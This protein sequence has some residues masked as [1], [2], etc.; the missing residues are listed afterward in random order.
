MGGYKGMDFQPRPRVTLAR[1]FPAAFESIVTSARTCY[2]RKGIVSSATIDEKAARLVQNLYNAGHHTTFQHSYF[3]FAI[4]NVSRLLVW[5]FLHSQ[6]Y[7]NSEQVSQRYVPVHRD[8]VLIPP[9]STYFR[10]R[11]IRIVETLMD[12]YQELVGRLIEP[13]EKVY[14]ER[15]PARRYQ[16]PRYRN[17]VEKK[18]MEVARYVLPLG[19]TTFLYHTISALTLLR[20]WKTCRS[21]D[22]PAEQ[23]I[24]AQQMV[25]AVIRKEPEYS[26]IL[27]E[28]FSE[29]SLPNPVDST[30][31]PG[32]MADAKA[33][34]DDFDQSLGGRVSCLVAA[35]LSAE[36]RVA[37]A[38][39][40][41][42]GVTSQRLSDEEALALAL[43]PAR[44]PT[45]GES[46]NTSMHM[47]L[48]RAMVVVNYTFKKKISHTADAQDQRHR[49]V[50]AARPALWAAWTGEPDYITPRLIREAPKEIA[51]LYH[52]TMEWLFESIHTLLKRG[53][54]PQYAAY[55]L[56]NAYPVRYFETGDLLNL[57]HKLSM[58]LCYNA[59]EEI[60]QASLDEWEQICQV[61][62]KIGSFLGPP[63]WIRKRAERR[64]F[65][66]EGERF[67]GI[68]VW[69]LPRERYSRI[70]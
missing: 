27:D 21:C 24:V 64:P 41:I 63:C 37:D 38:V 34:R 53:M 60:W 70:L 4:E 10:S 39:R 23:Q 9:L 33:F 26:K 36:Q 12:I 57:R 2:S 52:Q 28:P 5:S 43:D 20:Y 8:H 59:Q 35:D 46:L 40:T 68:R 31:L 22:V 18:A 1:T 29:E 42:L 48:S 45:L 6:P 16:S 51:Q 49:T 3:Q 55:L 61:H 67:C 69:E 54:E 17:A 44:N 58:R 13:A 65:C 30:R 11:Y 32:V 15:F 7:Y 62:P 14:Y 66:P 56:P 47:K 19:T 50:P 25:D